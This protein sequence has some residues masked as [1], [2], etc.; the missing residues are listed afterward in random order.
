MCISQT[1]DHESAKWKNLSCIEANKW[2]DCKSDAIYLITKKPIVCRRL[3]RLVPC[4]Q[5]Q[6]NKRCESTVLNISDTFIICSLLLILVVTV[7]TRQRLIE[8]TINGIEYPHI[9]KCKL[10]RS[11]PKP[12][13]RYIQSGMIIGIGSTMGQSFSRKWLELWLNLNV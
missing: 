9:N 2:L 13:G 5:Q 1:H 11:I 8:V 4:H 6:K 3:W 12:F 10:M 7:A